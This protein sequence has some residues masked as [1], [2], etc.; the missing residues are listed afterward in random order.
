MKEQPEPMTNFTVV[1]PM[2]ENK[3]TVKGFD[4]AE[5]VYEDEMVLHRVTEPDKSYEYVQKDQGGNV[6]NWFESL[7]WKMPVQRRLHWIRSA[8]LVWISLER[9]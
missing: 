2:G 8:I 1:L 9:S 3:I 4:Q 7:T 5:T 6:I